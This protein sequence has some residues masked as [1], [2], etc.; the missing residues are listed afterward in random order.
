M[1][2]T[3]W[4]AGKATMRRL[5]DAHPRRPRAAPAMA[6]VLLAAALATAAVAAK[7]APAAIARARAEPGY[8][9]AVL[10]GVLAGPADEPAAQRLLA[11]IARD[12][13]V[14]FVVY[15]GNLKG[16][17]EVCSDAVYDA[18]VA[19]LKSSRVPVFYVPGQADWAACATREAGGYDA[20][21][22][23]DY[24]RQTFLSDSESFGVTP[25]PLTRE[26]EVA[27]FRPFREN[28]RWTQGDT[29][30]VAINAPSPNNRYLTAGGRNGEFEDR[31]IANAFWIDHSAEF[32]KRRN[33]RAL[34]I[35]VEGDPQF[36]RYERE[37]FAWLRF[38]HTRRDGF[39]EF[40]RALVKA[41]ST[42]HGTILVIHASD[43]ALRGGFRIDQP[44]HDEKGD[45]IN[46]LTRI[47]IAPRDPFAQWIRITVNPAR[48][49]MF[50]VSVQAVPSNLPVPPAL[51]LIPR[52]DTPL[53]QMPEIPAVPE[54]PDSAG[55]SAVPGSVPASMPALP[56]GEDRPPSLP[57]APR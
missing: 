45:R 7:A 43:E 16:P 44:L 25:Q 1:N 4:P 31:A 29:V 50:G 30:F 20:V 6:A 49:P 24:L 3:R 34:V 51:P 8:G 42:F 5:T 26:S 57:A 15:D 47:A 40:K 53:P 9:F 21:E 35:L 39:L 27:R 56:E 32:A 18:R 17:H 46:N 38:G 19:L 52:D 55:A 48:R 37:R 28:I 23:L 54:I 10:S 41:T 22:R 12:R 13:G 11:A 14:A 36:E 33:A 2:C